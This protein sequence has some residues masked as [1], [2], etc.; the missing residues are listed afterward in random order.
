[1]TK[2]PIV[3]APLHVPKLLWKLS[4]SWTFAVEDLSLG[5]RHK[6][7]N[8]WL[9]AHWLSVFTC[10]WMKTNTITLYTF[11]QWYDM[12]PICPNRPWVIIYVLNKYVS[13][14]SGLINI[15]WN[16]QNITTYTL[17][18]G[19]NCTFVEDTV[20][21]GQCLVACSCHLPLRVVDWGQIYTDVKLHWTKRLCRI[22]KELQ[23]HWNSHIV[24]KARPR[25][26]R[27]MASVVRI[28]YDLFKQ[29][30]F[31]KYITINTVINIIVAVVVMFYRGRK[32]LNVNCN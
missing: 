4:E 2:L 29:K 7:I 1:M 27:H 32:P 14:N 13:D 20:D 18:S 30:I 21:S 25:L 5:D 10:E 17:D 23:F 26:F 15:F 19:T 22:S 12:T 9:T 28:I 3:V 8:F 6:S 24:R 16:R 11:V 31:Y